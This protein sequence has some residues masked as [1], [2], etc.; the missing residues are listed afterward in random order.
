MVKLQKL[1]KKTA[2][3]FNLPYNEYKTTRKAIIAHFNYLRLMGM[4]P[5]LQ[6]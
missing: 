1:L 6:A 2:K 5:K 4:K 3:E